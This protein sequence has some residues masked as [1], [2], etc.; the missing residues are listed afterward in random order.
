MSIREGLSDVEKAIWDEACALFEEMLD[1]FNSKNLLRRGIIRID[2]ERLRMIWIN[3]RNYALAFNELF[4][5]F[6]SEETVNEFV[7]KSGLN[8]QTLTAV[9]TSHMVGTLLVNFE[10]VFK[11]SLLFFLEEEEGIHKRMTLGQLL[12]SIERISPDIGARLNELINTNL[13]NSLAHGTFWFRGG[14]R[15]FLATNSYLEEIEE[16]PLVDFWIEVKKMSIISSALTHVL[17]IKINE[18]YFRI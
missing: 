8:H 9:F 5:I 10:S 12:R 17:H 18:G 2:R 11:T 15:V 6:K 16:I 14:G 13:R 7:S 3:S 4:R 1:D